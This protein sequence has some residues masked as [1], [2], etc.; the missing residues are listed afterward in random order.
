MR[1]NINIPRSEYY[2]VDKIF[3]VII[4]YTVLDDDRVGLA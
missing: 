1:N 4:K 3:A 2:I